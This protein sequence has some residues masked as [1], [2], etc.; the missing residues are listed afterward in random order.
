[1]PHVSELDIQDPIKIQNIDMFLTF[2]NGLKR[3]LNAQRA[4][5]L[6]HSMS[7][8]MHEFSKFINGYIG[9]LDVFILYIVYN[10]S[11]KSKL[12]LGSLAEATLRIN[13]E[14]GEESTSLSVCGNIPFD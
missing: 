7:S 5:T 11:I 1:M 9:K 6:Q 2:M 13:C 12:Q 3:M 8:K 4:Q 14:L 10:T